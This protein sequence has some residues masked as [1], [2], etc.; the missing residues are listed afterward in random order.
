MVICG[1]QHDAS[2]CHA[3]LS[4]V[5][6]PSDPSQ[7]WAWWP[8]VSM[9]WPMVALRSTAVVTALH[10]AYVRQNAQIWPCDSVCVSVCLTA[11]CLRVQRLAQH[12][13]YSICFVSSLWCCHVP[14]EGHKAVQNKLQK[15][16]H[17]G[18]QPKSQRFPN[19]QKPPAY[20]REQVLP[21]A[22]I[23]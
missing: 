23:L 6:P 14:Q 5:L 7:W 19:T 17:T 20:R 3:A 2:R 21:N 18:R 12:H 9:V 8:I 10:N 11:A 4:K 16:R 13:L 1:V 22:G 15:T